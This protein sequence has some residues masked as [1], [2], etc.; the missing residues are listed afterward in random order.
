[1]LGVVHKV[2]RRRV[3]LR[4]E[5]MKYIYLSAQKMPNFYYA[6]WK[7][8]EIFINDDH[9]RIENDMVICFVVFIVKWRKKHW[10]IE[11]DGFHDSCQFGKTGI[12]CS[13]PWLLSYP[14]GIVK[15]AA[16]NN[17]D[18]HSSN[19]GPISPMLE[20]EN[21]QEDDAAE[22]VRHE[23]Q[24]D[25]DNL[26]RW[27][28]MFVIPETVPSMGKAQEVKGANK[29]A[30]IVSDNNRLVGQPT[31]AVLEAQVGAAKRSN[32]GALNQSVSQAQRRKTS[33]EKAKGVVQFH[34]KRKAL[35][36]PCVSIK[37]GM[38]LWVRAYSPAVVYS[39]LETVLHHHQGWACGPV[40]AEWCCLPCVLLLIN[41]SLCASIKV[42][43]ALWVRAYSP[44][45]VYSVLEIVLHH[46]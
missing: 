39:V 36:L 20:V 10:D 37:V 19:G 6:Q 11:R 24:K 43:M 12:P 32:S 44:T 15:L 5:P 22:V 45:V 14:P 41:L 34:G 42:G 9:S 40:F 18:S 46:H 7:T 38:A 16:K 33:K 3:L 25:M 31:K 2:H 13:E 21:N 28:S 29:G 1:M 30:Q 4:C 8:R 35:L 17:D 23:K 27:L 26:D